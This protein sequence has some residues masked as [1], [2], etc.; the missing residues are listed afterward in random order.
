MTEKEI[1]QIIKK[2]LGFSV[3]LAVVPILFLVFINYYSGDDSSL[4]ILIAPITAIGACSYL[5]KSV[6]V[7]IY[8]AKNT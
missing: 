8:A 5:I 7:D 3:F 6:L 4:P 1:N 2:H